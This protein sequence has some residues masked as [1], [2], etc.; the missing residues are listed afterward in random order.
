MKCPKY[1]KALIYRRAKLATELGDA[2]ARL[3]EWLEKQGILEKLELYDYCTG[4]EMYVNPWASAQR[5][6]EAIEEE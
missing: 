6:M 1:I 2:D 5:I 4:A 3:C